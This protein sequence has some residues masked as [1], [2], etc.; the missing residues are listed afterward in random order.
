MIIKFTNFSDGIHNLSFN[1]PVEKLK[2]SSEF[3]DKVLLEVEMDKSPSQLVLT[4]DVSATAH[5]ICDRCTKEYDTE[6]NHSFKMTY[7]IGENFGSEDEEEQTDV[8][9]LNSDEDKIDLQNDVTE[10]TQ[11]ALPMK[12]I[13]SDDCK[14]LCPKC[15]A[16]L[17]EKSCNCKDDEIDPAWEP[18]LKLKD[19]LK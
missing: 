15:G 1:E 8:H 19:K 9:Y 6:V 5:R 2:L 17:N 11:L 18:L 3:I 7:L 4:C 14:G 13:C 16:D 10:L 12:S